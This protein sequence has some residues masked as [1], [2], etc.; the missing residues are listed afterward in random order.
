MFLD[1]AV[2]VLGRVGVGPYDVSWK[3]GVECD[4]V[5]SARKMFPLIVILLDLG[6]PPLECFHNLYLGVQGGWVGS[7][8]I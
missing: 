7:E 2:E 8:Y 4:D 6:Y 5:W 3:C 1:L